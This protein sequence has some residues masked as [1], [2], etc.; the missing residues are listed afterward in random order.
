KIKPKLEKLPNQS[1][2]LYIKEAL[3]LLLKQ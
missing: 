1:A 2:D 3:K